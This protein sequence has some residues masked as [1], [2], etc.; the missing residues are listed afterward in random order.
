MTRRTESQFLVEVI[1]LL[2]TYGWRYYHT[3]DS[4]RSVAGFPDLICVRGRRLLAL[5]L[6]MADGHISEAQREWI[7]ALAA[8]PG[9]EAFIVRYS[10]NYSQLVELLA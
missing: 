10:D 6:K 4:R 8:V 1:S 7:I 9:V 2:K 3:H 5:E